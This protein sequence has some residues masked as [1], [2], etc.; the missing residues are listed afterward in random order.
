MIPTVNPSVVVE[1]ID[2]A[3][4]RV[5]VAWESDPIAKP[6]ITPSLRRPSDTI[7][8]NMQSNVEQARKTV[9]VAASRF[10]LTDRLDPP[11]LAEQLRDSADFLDLGL[12][13]EFAR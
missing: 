6:W 8:A 3:V 13:D 12:E 4:R 10:D 11:Q 9:S 7:D 5:I 2:N 1:A